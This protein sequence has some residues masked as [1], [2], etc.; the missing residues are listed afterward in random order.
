MV[1][2]I[3]PHPLHAFGS[4]D[5]G[6]GEGGSMQATGPFLLAP[7]TEPGRNWALTGSGGGKNLHKF[8]KNGK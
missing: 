3:L 4:E 6:V 8:N 2:E 5:C 7:G 1:I